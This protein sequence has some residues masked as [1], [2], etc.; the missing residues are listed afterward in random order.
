VEV[1][2]DDSIIS[3]EDVTIPSFDESEEYRP[4]DDSYSDNNNTTTNN[5]NTIGY[6]KASSSNINTASYKANATNTTNT[7][8]TTKKQSYDND[9]DDYNDDFETDY[10]MESPKS[11]AQNN[12]NKPPPPITTTTTTTASSSSYT[13]D[14]ISIDQSNNNNILPSLHIQSL[15]TELA[16][17]EISK[18]VLRLRNQQRIVL[19]ERKIIA[20]EKKSRAL[21]R[22]KEYEDNIKYKTLKIEELEVLNSILKEK[23]ESLQKQL[24]WN[25]NS[26]NALQDSIN[27]LND[28]I[29]SLTTRLH[30][31]ENARNIA[32]SE[33]IILQE[34]LKAAE[35]TWLHEKKELIDAKSKAEMMLD[36][37]QKNNN[38]IE[39]KFYKERDT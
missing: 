33:Y 29:L 18:E 12:K 11:K 21:Q 37:V 28:Q 15:Q 25:D 14:K 23:N 17:E 32:R 9:Y 5:T 26:K 7:T 27:L 19:K 34:S 36:V 13:N 22:R 4:A 20:E 24:I 10:S 39:T 6:N 2:E 30:D 8:T 1:M 38:D 16:L 3:E 35:S 31:T